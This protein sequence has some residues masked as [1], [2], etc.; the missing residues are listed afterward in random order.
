MPEGTLASWEPESKKGKNLESKDA[1]P[2]PDYRITIPRGK[3][4]EIKVRA[5]RRLGELLQEMPKAKGELL[6]GNKPLP[7]DDTPT[8]EDQGITRLYSARSRA[9]AFLGAFYGGGGVG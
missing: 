7:R 3:R 4:T 6:R 2:S 8:L 9:H 5:E 1:S